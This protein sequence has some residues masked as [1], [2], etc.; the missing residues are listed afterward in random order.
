MKNPI[1][2][3]YNGLKC[4]KRPGMACTHVC[5]CRGVLNVGLKI[6]SEVDFLCIWVFTRF[7]SCQWKKIKQYLLKSILIYRRSPVS[8]IL[9][10]PTR[11]IG[12]TALIGDWFSPWNFND[13]WH[14]TCD[15]WQILTSWQNL[16]NNLTL[17][18]T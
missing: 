9:G 8:A 13:C 11:T 15:M 5:S 7:Y 10:S 18:T 4:I 2:C 17:I 1:N 12:K 6:L 16:M 14:V 3:F